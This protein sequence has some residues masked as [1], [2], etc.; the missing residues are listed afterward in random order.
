MKDGAPHTVL[1][2]ASAEC[3][4]GEC[5]NPCCNATTCMLKEGSQCG[6]GECCENCQVSWYET[7]YLLLPALDA[8]MWLLGQLWPSSGCLRLCVPF[9]LQ[10]YHLHLCFVLL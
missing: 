7:M 5:T 2:E 1:W 8:V 6:D 10:C 4:G 3:D 9:F